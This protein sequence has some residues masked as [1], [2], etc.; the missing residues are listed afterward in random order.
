MDVSRSANLS[1]LIR[2]GQRAGEWN[3]PKSCG[4]WG[5]G[6]LEAVYVSSSN[7]SPESL[8]W[9]G[10]P[11]RD[12]RKSVY[13]ILRGGSRIGDPGRQRM[14]AERGGLFNVTIWAQPVRNQPNHPR[15]GHDLTRGHKPAAASH[16]LG[17]L[18]FHWAGAGVLVPPSW[19][20][21]YSRRAS[22]AISEVDLSFNFPIRSSRFR[23]L[24]GTL[25]PMFASCLIRIVRQWI[26]K[27]SRPR[28]QIL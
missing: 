6:I 21:A 15:R 28:K 27:D 16:T 9:A 4:D 25:K 1:L 5:M 22:R 11:R 24:G 17:G 19:R 12:H 20:S 23:R 10:K 18:L 13:D 26:T 14:R 3:G 7:R 2:A 8:L